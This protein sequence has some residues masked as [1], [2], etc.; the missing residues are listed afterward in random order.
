MPSS[1]FRLIDGTVIVAYL[2]SMAVISY[3]IAR[4][5]RNKEDY[6]V[7]GRKMHWF[8][9][10][11]SGVAAGFSAVS[12]MGVPGFVMAEDMR[13]L[14]TLFLGVISI[15]IV[16]YFLLPFL[17]R[18]KIVSVYEYLE[19]RF[20]VTIRLLASLM[21]MFSKLGYLAMVILTP[22]LA[23][24]AVTGW[25]LHLLIVIFG[26]ITTVYTV[27][28]G[29]EGVIW[30]ELV[31]YFVIIGGV[32][33]VV[34]F[35][36]FSPDAGEPGQYWQIAADAGKTRTF[37]FKVGIDNMSV[38]VLILSGTI[39]GVAGMC[40]D[41]T[42]IQRYFAARSIKH[43]IKGYIFSLIFGTPLVLILYFVGAWMF[44]FFNSTQVLPPEFADQ[45]D[46]VFPYFVAKY[47][48]PG[49]SG[50]ILAGI[51]A[52]GMST[53]SAVIHS[54]TSLTM[55]DFYEKYSK[56]GTEKGRHYVTISRCVS[57]VWGILAIFLA[58][59]VMNIG[60]TIIEVNTV[61]VGFLSAPLGGIYFLGIF[62]KRANNIGV[63]VGGL[64]GVLVNAAAFLLN[65]Y[66]IITIHF[67]WFGLFGIFATVLVGYAVSLIFP[68]Q[69]PQSD[70]CHPEK[71]P[72]DNATRSLSKEA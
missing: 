54:L 20:S 32:L 34:L 65:R 45:P 47:M 10:A 22:S 18:L 68:G 4:R 36:C 39:F 15:P 67:M 28:G 69:T 27:A 1:G 59:F 53:I 61:I 56:K 35:L 24:A 46:R 41:Q 52:A 3:I 62:T 23:L 6:L 19:Q 43:A 13:F 8:P 63:I 5:Q 2:L 9:V 26:L 44:G 7:A 33:A 72:Q 64:A 30:T 31:Q 25:N 70:N 60:K 21:F 71:P 29:L 16:F 14:P 66:G 50:L 11:L 58:F 57:F 48:P 38:W 17:Y 55:V 12:L 49:L 40:N 37:D 42:N 51:F